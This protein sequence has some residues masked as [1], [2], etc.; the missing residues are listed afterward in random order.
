YLIAAF[1]LDRRQA[2]KRHAIA[3]LAFAPAILAV[4]VAGTGYFR[5]A[6]HNIPLNTTALTQIGLQAFLMTLA[7]GIV[8]V[9]GG[10]VGIWRPRERAWSAFGAMVAVF[11]VLLIS[12]IGIFSVTT[13]AKFRE[14]YLFTLAPLVA[15]SFGIY[16]K[17]RCPHKWAVFIISVGL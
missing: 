1:L 11:S 16:L 4:V 12:E 10:V 5:S 9:P 13:L 6:M 3:L 8:I 17:R 14:R 15:L 2:V 7:A